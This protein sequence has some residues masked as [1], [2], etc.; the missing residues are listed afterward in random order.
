MV[1]SSG[2][3]SISRTSSDGTSAWL[4]IGSNSS[5]VVYNGNGFA[6]CPFDLGNIPASYNSTYHWILRDNNSPAETKSGP[7]AS[8]LLCDPRMNLS[9]T[10]VTFS[11]VTNSLSVSSEALGSSVGNISPA[12][13]ALVLAQSLLD[14][15]DIDGTY[16]EPALSFVSAKLFLKQLPVNFDTTFEFTNV[17]SSLEISSRIGAYVSSAAKAWSDGYWE[18]NNRSTIAVDAVK[19]EPR[20]ALAGGVSSTIIAGILAV[21]VLGLTAGL[22][23]AKTAEPLGIASLKE[24]MEKTTL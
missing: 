23:G 12:S 18:I 15:T 21:L 14:I 16:S 17:S 2:D 10:L 19:Q 7:L 11:P 5:Y 1:Q 9:S 13:A 6:D 20:L 3:N 8:L 4:F 24:A 22:L